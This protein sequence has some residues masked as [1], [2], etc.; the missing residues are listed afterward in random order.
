MPLDPQARTYL[1]E[2]AALGAPPP[3]EQELAEVR[4]ANET[5][6]PGL[7]GPVP[8]VPFEDRAVPGPAG[9]IGVRVYSGGGADAP[10]LVYFHGGGWVIGSLDTHHGVCATLAQE[11]GCTVVSVDY[12]LAPEH[13][14]PAALDDAW[15]ATVW[16]SEH[17][18]ELGTRSGPVAVGG[19]S[20]GGNLAAVVAVWARDGGLP[21]AR[22]LLVYPV[23]DADFETPSYREFAEGVGLTRAGMR[24]FWDQY[25]PEEE[26]RLVVEASPLRAG[27]LRGVAPASVVTAEYD[28]LRDEGEAYAQKLEEAGVPVTLSRYDGLIHGFLRMPA[29][30]D[31]ARESLS[32]AAAALRAAF[33]ASA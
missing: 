26:K 14:F 22:Q 4:Q 21:L 6:A 27:D 20:S 1:D 17:P 18:A 12:R 7:F 28:V 13:P 24:W 33:A 19:D 31:R 25:L 11:A 5:A 23:C 16:A 8:P 30:L 32:E 2:L 9:R 15:A 29:V 10:A 3:W